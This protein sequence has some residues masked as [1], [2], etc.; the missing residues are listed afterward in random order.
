MKTFQ[1]L[2]FSLV[3]G[4][5][6]LVF[7]ADGSVTITAPADGATIKANTETKLE[8]EISPGARGDHFHLYI[9]GKENVVRALKG[10]YTLPKFNPGKHT[11]TLKVVD[12]GH[13]PT[14][15]EKT[16]TVTAE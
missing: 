15:L 5:A 12:K 16:I 13:T 7:A 8:Y 2:L 10:S 14:G 9:D 4:A 6:T 11:V 3:F 1:T